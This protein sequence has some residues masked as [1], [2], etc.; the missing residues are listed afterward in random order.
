MNDQKKDNLPHD[1][2]AEYYDFVYRQTY[3]SL[4]DAFTATSLNAIT[5][6]AGSGSAA[7]QDYGAGTGRL[8]IP[9]AQ[10]G[11]DVIAVEQSA[12]MLNAFRQKAAA[13]NLEIET[14]N[15]SIQNYQGRTADLAI[16][17]FTV[18][19]YSVDE[20]VLQAIFRNISGHLKSEGLFFFD[21]AD[22]VFF[23]H[24]MP[25]IC[26]GDFKR[27]FKITPCGNNIYE[28]RESCKGV[29]DGNEF[30]Y[31]DSFPLRYWKFEEVNVMLLNAGFTRVNKQFP[32]FRGTGSTYYLYR[33]T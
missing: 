10:N 15:S 20:T 3:G 17:V 12:P 26:K 7:I 11:H 4:Y 16:C 30:M 13:L 31:A 29:M 6:L 2:W 9:H 8:S 5:K 32:E 23:G 19:N 25:D 22:F 27:L 1:T 14:V 28:Y 21:L 33:K 18:L 24:G